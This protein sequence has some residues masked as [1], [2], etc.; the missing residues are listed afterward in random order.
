MKAIILTVGAG[1]LI[2]GTGML[3][4]SWEINYK[5]VQIFQ[6]YKTAKKVQEA[7]GNPSAFYNIH[8]GG[9]NEKMSVRE[10]YLILGGRYDCN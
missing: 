9:F 4:N 6:M 10:A 2:A 3:L 5:R 8:E 1:L 7:Y